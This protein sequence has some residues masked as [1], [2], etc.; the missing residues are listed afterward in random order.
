M[1]FAPNTVALSLVFFLS[2]TGKWGGSHA[3]EDDRREKVDVEIV[4]AV[5]TSDSVSATEH[6]AQVEGMARAFET[7]GFQRILGGL[8]TGKMAVSVLYWAGREQQVFAVPW[9]VISDLPTARAFARKIRDRAKKPWPTLSYTA[10]GEAMTVAAEAIMDNRFEGERKII[11][12]SGD[13]PANIGLRPRDVRDQLVAAGF[14]INGLPVLADRRDPESRRELVDYFEREVV[15]GKQSFL[16][17]A[18]T[19]G[20]Y[21]EAFYRKFLSEISG[22]QPDGLDAYLTA[23]ASRDVPGRNVTVHLAKRPN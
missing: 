4:L 9:A 19:F 21:A 18:L 7:Q 15:G 3:A 13:D 2:I 12:L 17:P 22:V 6:L 16:N 8:K 11:D 1:N 14:T 5:D 23:L 10:I 20:H